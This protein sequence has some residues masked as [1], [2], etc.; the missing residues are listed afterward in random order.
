MD[1]KNILFITTSYSTGNPF[2]PILPKLSKDHNVDILNLFQMSKYTAWKEKWELDPRINFYK[3]CDDNNITSIH[4]PKVVINKDVNVKTYVKWRK[5]IDD[6]IKRNYY[7][8][9]LID[10]NTH[11][12]RMGLG[13]IYQHFV[14]QG[15]PYIACPHGNKDYVKA[16][17]LKRVGRLYDYSFVFGEKEKR[18]MCKV[19]KK[20]AGNAHRLLPAG[21]PASD[22]LKDYPRNNK[23]ILL[24]M[25]F[26]KKPP[27]GGQTAKQKPFTI[28]TF[29][30]L[31]LA[32]LSEE[33]N[34]PIIIKEKYRLYY[35]DL[36]LRKS[37][38]KYKSIV[39][40]MSVC[41][42]DNKLMADSACVISAGSTLA[43]K[44]VQLGVPTVILN[45]FG[46][47]GNFSDFP[48]LMN[49]DPKKMRES[50]KWQRDQG[51]LV[52]FISDTITGG[53]EYNSTD[54]YIDYINKFL[55]GEMLCR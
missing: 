47:N 10:N 17:Y 15:I 2:H 12:K 55:S 38:K 19:D 54:I 14:E 37:L 16:K 46:M 53:L 13:N 43:L 50:F 22:R 28:E 36:S 51:R 34:C 44:P 24:I 30:H 9:V 26:T 39:K 11:W 20:R 49:P 48:G 40:F 41:E 3:M 23:H 7:D 29:K 42:D 5:N 27:K 45:R 33:Y 18:E 6:S 8:L 25:N 1:R 31:K 35:E 4:A 32:K 21:L 52:N